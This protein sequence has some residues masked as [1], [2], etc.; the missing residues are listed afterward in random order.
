MVQLISCSWIHFCIHS[1]PVLSRTSRRGEKKKAEGK[2][3]SA[4]K[5]SVTR[6][7]SKLKKKKKKEAN[8]ASLGVP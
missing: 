4:E 5:E 2:K 3:V 6:T 7:L 1:V 8:H